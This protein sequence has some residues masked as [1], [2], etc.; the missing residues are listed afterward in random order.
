MSQA[1]LP[2]VLCADDF[3][4]N[5]SVSQA[6]SRLADAGRITATS[7]MSL[8]PRWPQDQAL[9]RDLAGSIDVGLHPDWTSDFAQAAGHGLSLGSVMRQALI[10]GF[11]GCAHK[12]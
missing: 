8:S 2:L 1:V 12:R 7:V 3:A 10:G 4:F 6:I 9:L 5:P 11:D